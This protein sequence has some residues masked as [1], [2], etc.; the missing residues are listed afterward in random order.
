[1]VEPLEEPPEGCLAAD[2]LLLLDFPSDLELNPPPHRRNRNPPLPAAAG[3][4]QDQSLLDILDSTVIPAVDGLA[5]LAAEGGGDGEDEEDL[6]W[7][8]NK[9]AFPALETSFEI[10][11]HSRSSSGGGTG[12]SNSAAATAAEGARPSPVSV[13]AVAARS[14]VPVR[15][16]S[17]GRRLRRRV[18]AALSPSVAARE[19]KERR[20]CRHCDAEETPQWRAGP[21]GPKTLCN[22]CGVRYKS[23]RLVPEYRPAASPTFS[24]AIHSNSHRRIMEM[25]RRNSVRS[26]RTGR[27]P[28]TALVSGSSL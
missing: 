23:G 16:R 19:L 26:R 13:L 12:S 21:E 18:L 20:R 6:E 14:R 7:L 4:L 25:R 24:A 28:A 15:P 9:D 17:K 11:T 27:P 1:M 22:A 2:D 8:S 3:G 5:G 10:P